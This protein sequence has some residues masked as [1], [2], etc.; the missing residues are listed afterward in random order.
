LKQ[1]LLPIFG[2][3][4]L[5]LLGLGVGF[6]V[7]E[8]GFRM[9]YPDPAPKLA[10]QGLQ[11]HEQYGLAFKPGAE[12]WNTSLRGE[13]STYIKINQ[14]GLR[15]R[16]YGYTKQAGVFRIL[17]LGDSFTAGLQ[18]SEAETFPKLL[19]AQLNQRYPQT[20]F[21]VINAGV[22]GY[23]THNQLA[24]YLHEGYKYQADLVLLAFFTGNDLTDNIWYSLYQL[25][26]GELVSVP[27]TNRQS[28]SSPSSGQPDSFFKQVRNFLYT[29]SR[30]YSVSIELLTFSA[31]QRAPGL[32]QLLVSLGFIEL[33]QPV[34]NYGNLYVFRRLPD[35]AW[36]TSQALLLRLNQEVEAH[37]SQLLV[38][39]LPD[40]TDVDEA[41]RQDILERYGHLIKAQTVQGPP[42]AERLAQILQR[43]GIAYLPLLP[44]LQKGQ[45]EAQTPL[46]FRYDGHWT[47]AGHQVAG[48]AIFEYLVENGDK[49]ANFP[50]LTA[51][52]K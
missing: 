15:D 10:N 31:I 48:Q 46:Y 38:A 13:Y 44:A 42:P 2:R 28:G 3:L 50:A 26:D 8:M 17:V 43:T 34:V 19:E 21:E 24:Y 49:W 22:V 25:K 47:P 7:L 9:L 5:I 29:H 39:I 18:V 23:G 6:I 4:S 30:L 36:A 12:G 20:K 41:R 11:F 16:D 33:T 35:E 27:A 52:Q 14:R 51:S 40:E 37:G 1:K 32:A 45:R